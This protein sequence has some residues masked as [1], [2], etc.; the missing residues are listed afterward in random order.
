MNNCLLTSAGLTMF[1]HVLVIS[2]PYGSLLVKMAA[3]KE[4]NYRCDRTA[5]K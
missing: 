5:I 1:L 4:P 3:I 2:S